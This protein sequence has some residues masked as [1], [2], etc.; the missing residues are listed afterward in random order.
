MTWNCIVIWLQPRQFQLASWCLLCCPLQPFSLPWNIATWS[1]VL[2][3][4][5]WS[6]WCKSNPLAT[7][8]NPPPTKASTGTFCE[9]AHTSVGLRV[10]RLKALITSEL[11]LSFLWAHHK[12]I[13]AKQTAK[14]LGSWKIWQRS[15]MTTSESSWM[16]APFWPLIVFVLPFQYWT[17][18]WK[19]LTKLSTSGWL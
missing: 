3:W 12:K 14:N 10:R 5:S 15:R 8:D 6:P 7:F 17:Y 13:M 19:S 1:T 2:L 9:T 4:P 16:D 11:C 18:A